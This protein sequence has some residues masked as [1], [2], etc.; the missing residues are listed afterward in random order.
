M[1]G[2]FV[3]SSLYEPWI[4]HGQGLQVT[5]TARKRPSKLVFTMDICHTLPGQIFLS[6]KNKTLQVAVD[7]V[8]PYNN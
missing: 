7:V 3:L 2:N 4:C 8:K 6:V 1:S 5:I